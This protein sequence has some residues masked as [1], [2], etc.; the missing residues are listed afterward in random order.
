MS[1]KHS[2]SVQ[3]LWG[4][5][6]TNKREIGQIYWLAFFSGLVSL[7][8]PFGIQSIINFIQGGTYSVSYYVLII[9]ITIG[10]IIYAIMQ[11][12][13]LR[14]IE[15]IQQKIFT[16]AGIEFAFRFPKIKIEELLNINARDLANRF[17]D[18]IVLEKSIVKF[19]IDFSISAMQILISAIVI[20][21][22]HESYLVL[23]LLVL[24]ILYFGFR[25]TFNKTLQTGIEYSKYKYKTAYWI[26]EV[27]NASSTFKLAGEMQL[28]LIKTDQLLSDYLKK[29]EEHYKWLNI[30][31]IVLNIVKTVYVLGFLLIGGIMVMEQRM[32]IG[33]FVAS[34]V[35][36]LT[37]VN[38]I[39]KII[40]TLKNMYDMFISLEKLA[41]VTDLSIEKKQ[42]TDLF[43]THSDNYTSIDSEGMQVEVINLSF[44]YPKSNKLILN[45]LTFSVKSKEKVLITGMNN[46]GKTTLIKIISS[47]YEI[48]NGDI[49][50]NGISIKN[51]D[52]ERLRKDIGIYF[53]E[54]VIFNGTVW[55]NITLGRKDADTKFIYD[56][57]DKIN[58]T[59][60]IELLENGY[61]TLIHSHGYG[62][63]LSTMYKI[64]FL[65]TVATKP[66]L[67]L[68]ENMHL[69]FLKDD[70]T[71]FIEILTNKNQPWTLFCIDELD[72][73][74]KHYDT[75]FILEKGQLIFKGTYSELKKS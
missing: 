49:K 60:E 35:L 64:L 36:I 52:K 15:N 74:A 38:G 18:V 75:I 9:L 71:K 10:I 31:Y 48:T 66:K 33:Q 8:L 72:D 57:A 56:I 22:Y 26:E 39:D 28:P 43:Y 70:R 14:I 55:E 25:Y 29:R 51:I 21:L 34:E 46:S 53:Q 6:Q 32:N 50:Y 44:S 65:R 16:Y 13:E 2:N 69:N 11:I 37:I 41:E 30:Q 3:R 27:A 5:L 4:L 61:N 12:V 45:N 59:K 67:L 7:T 63:P 23:N 17:F 68:V 47:L 20:C 1:K 62:L 58:L 73:N 40:H 54:D 19:L 24:I 42:K